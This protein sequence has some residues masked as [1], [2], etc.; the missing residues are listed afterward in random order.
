[1]A[2]FEGFSRWKNP[3]PCPKHFAK[4]LHTLKADNR[5]W[6]M[7]RGKTKFCVNRCVICFT[8]YCRCVWLSLL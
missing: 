1:L 8:C 2:K 6:G 5:K 3:H 4:L 7:V